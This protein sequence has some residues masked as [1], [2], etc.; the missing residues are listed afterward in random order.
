M[1]PPLADRN[2]RA[3]V[4]A[5]G[6]WVL[7]PAAAAA[8][9][10]R[11]VGYFSGGAGPE[12]IAPL[13]AELGWVVGQNLQFEV[14]IDGK[15]DP[16]RTRELA[17]EL[18]RARVDALLTFSPKR[19]RALADVTKTIPI[20]CMLHDPVGEGFARSLRRPGG[21]ITGI[22]HGA[23]EQ[24]S[25]AVYL[26]KA[27]RPGIR[28]VVM[29]EPRERLDSFAGAALD[30]IKGAGIQVDHVAVGSVLNYTKDRKLQGMTAAAYL[31]EVE[32]AFAGIRDPEHSV[33]S[34]D[35]MPDELIEEIAARAIRGR[36]ATMVDEP[37]LVRR[38]FLF[39]GGIHHSDPN[40]RLVAVLDKVLRGG[41]PAE[42]PFELP[43]RSVLVINRRTAEAIGVPLSSEI[44]LRA[45]EMVG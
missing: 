21:N 23:P 44:L 16:A 39:W 7:V 11:R 43:D 10:P 37:G 33:A 42:I 18:V 29:I 19:V 40:R 22:S 17:A 32:R 1:D 35:W 34:L 30:A 41:N 31:A 25:F 5:A 8:E 9:R 27:F 20:V 14:R 24:A 45:T 3:L 36:I 38:G 15:A 6:A 12:S 4:L 2:R 28:R 13:L 26:L